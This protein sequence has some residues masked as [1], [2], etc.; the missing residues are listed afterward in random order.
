MLAFRFLEELFEGLWPQRQDD[1]AALEPEPRLPQPADIIGRCTECHRDVMRR[2]Q[3]SHDGRLVCVHCLPVIYGDIGTLHRRLNSF[4]A[5]VRPFALIFGKEIVPSLK[6]LLVKGL[7][8]AAANA[9]LDG[10]A[11]K[12]RDADVDDIRRRRA[13]NALQAAR[14][15]L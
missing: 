14:S 5:L 12:L 9:Y 7:D 8:H 2:D 1:H 3:A 4:E 15:L 10:L 6:T 11:Q 13:E